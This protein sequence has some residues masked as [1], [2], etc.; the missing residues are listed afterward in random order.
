MPEGTAIVGNGYDPSARSRARR[1]PAA[2]AARARAGR[3]DVA[4]RA[5]GAERRPVGRAGRPD[6]GRTRRAGPPCSASTST[7]RCAPRPSEPA[8]PSTPAD[9]GCR[10]SWRPRARQGRAR[11]RLSRCTAPAGGDRRAARLAARGLRVLA[12]ATRPV[13]GD[14]PTATDEAERDLTLLGL[15]ALDDPPR[16]RAGDALAACRRAG[17][18]VAMITGDHPDTARA[19]AREVGLSGR[20]DPVI[21]GHDLPADR[22]RL[23]A[24]L[25]RDGDRR[26]PG[27]A[28]GQAP[29]RQ[30]VAGPRTRRRHDRRRGQR[31]PRPAEAAIGVAW[32]QSGTD[33]ARE[34]AD[35]VLLDDD[36]GTIVAAVE[37][38]RATFANIRRFLTYHLTDNV[39]ELAPFVVWALSGGTLPLAIGVLQVLAL[40]I[41]TDLCPR[42]R[43]A[44]N[45]PARHVL[46]RPPARGHLSTAACCRAFGILGPV[47]ASSSWP[48]RRLPP[49]R[50]L[51][52]RGNPSPTG[53]RC[54]PPPAP[55]SPR[56]C[57]GQWRTLRVPQHVRPGLA[58]PLWA[59]TGCCSAPSLPSSNARRIPLYPAPRAP[60]RPVA[61]AP[62]RFSRRR[63]RRPCGPRRGHS[64]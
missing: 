57:F 49:R 36:F 55:R 18:K 10:S 8:S 50:R 35:L 39:A 48:L 59:I 21:T 6:G 28:R 47:E 27:G 16:P 40:D 64:P 41:G 2:P 22:R 15:V 53:R 14:V 25:D 52:V 32:A 17:I 44:P 1:P 12:V 13:A 3:G 38:G 63:T 23:G 7:P 29:H 9:A 24:L 42:W 60:A 56:S 19:I 34:A 51:A 20:D 61:A 4:H 62:R 54:W 58:D 37:Q 5:S 30:G 31:R 33:V 26:R 46:E 11:R 45:H 43:S